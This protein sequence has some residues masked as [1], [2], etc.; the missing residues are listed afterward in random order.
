MNID[1]VLTLAKQALEPR[2]APFGLE[3]VEVSPYKDWVGEDAL[4]VTARLRPDGPVIPGAISADAMGAL[5]DALLD[6][7]EERFPY[8]RFDHQ[9]DEP[10]EDQAETSGLDP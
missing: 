6:H 8:L 4:T 1:E 5:S 10:I 9:E 3:S 7:G 2:L